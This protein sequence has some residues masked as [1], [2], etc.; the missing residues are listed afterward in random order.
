MRISQSINANL[1]S[2]FPRPLL[3]SAPDLG[4][5]ES[6]SLQK[7]VKHRRGYNWEVPQIQIDFKMLTLKFKK[8]K[9]S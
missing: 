8:P 7:L 1:H 4:Q 6:S 2:A 5:A 3:I 9:K